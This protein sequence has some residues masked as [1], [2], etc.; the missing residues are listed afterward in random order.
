LE[1]DEGEEKTL[2]RDHELPNFKIGILLYIFKSFNII[3]GAGAISAQLSL[4]L[5]LSPL[6]LRA[7]LFIL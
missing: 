6:F 4:P 3:F 7:V 5:P 2:S 1:G